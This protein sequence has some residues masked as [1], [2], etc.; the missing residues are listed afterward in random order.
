MKG[1]HLKTCPAFTF[2]TL[3]FMWKLWHKIQLSHRTSVVSCL[4]EYPKNVNGHTYCKT[5]FTWSIHLVIILSKTSISTCCTPE[6]ALITKSC[7]LGLNLVIEVLRKYTRKRA[8]WW[9]ITYSSKTVHININGA[10]SVN[11]LYCQQLSSALYRLIHF[12]NQMYNLPS[13]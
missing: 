9:K 5:K 10:V 4:P 2:I 12:N 3:G 6:H 1:A 11:V 13:K 8:V 7:K